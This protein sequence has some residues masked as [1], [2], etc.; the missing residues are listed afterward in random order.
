LKKM[1]KKRPPFEGVLEVPQLARPLGAFLD[2]SN[3]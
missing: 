3:A 1:P 2:A